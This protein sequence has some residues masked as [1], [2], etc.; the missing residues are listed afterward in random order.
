MENLDE[1]ISAL[2]VQD[3]DILVVRSPRALY[4]DA[5]R[6]IALE[7]EKACAKA[8]FKCPVLVLDSGLLIDV[9]RHVPGESPFITRAELPTLIREAENKRL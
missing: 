5:A 1:R 3:G 4:T 9:I 7:L 8:G 2:S 6:R